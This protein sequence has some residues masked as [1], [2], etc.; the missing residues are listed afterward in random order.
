M[1]AGASSGC[2]Y[3]TQCS[4]NRP[5]PSSSLFLNKAKILYAIC[6]LVHIESPFLFVWFFGHLNLSFELRVRDLHD[7]SCDLGIQLSR[8]SCEHCRIR[9]SCVIQR[10]H[11]SVMVDPEKPFCDLSRASGACKLLL[12]GMMCSTRFIAQCVTETQIRVF[13]FFF[14]ADCLS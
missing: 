8:N 14:G 13:S 11:R 9:K 5:S 6:R 4:A 12:R 7:A 10:L 1:H 3:T 2:R